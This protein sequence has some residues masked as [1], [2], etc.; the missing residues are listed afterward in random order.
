L[1]TDE[2]RINDWKANPS[3]SALSQKWGIDVRNVH[4][5][6][7]RVEGKYNIELRVKEHA[8][9][10]KIPVQKVGYRRQAEIKGGEVIVGSDI[11]EWPGERSVAFDAFIK[12]IQRRKPKMVIL[13]GDSLDGS[14]ISRH[15]PGGWADLPELADEL[16]AVQERMGE[17]E[18]V[19][20]EIPLVF[21]VGN[22]DARFSST[23]A[24]KAPDFIKINGT[25]LSDHL[26]AWNFC[27]SI[28]I[29]DDVVIKH[30]W[31]Q[32]Q[33]AKWQNVLKSGKTMVTG[34]THRLHFEAFKDYNDKTR[35]GIEC[36]T[37]MEMSTESDKLTWTEDAPLN[38]HQGFVVLTFDEDGTLLE[39]EFCR[40]IKGFAY[41]RGEKIV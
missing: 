40:V 17:V 12:L 36:G 18:S 4:A 20:G 15:P 3:P 41:F 29:N 23:L 21:P 28:W 2:Q 35:Y 38:W 9:K 1:D 5:W 25:D 37:L 16:A 24:Q 26:P 14:K 11:H 22:H 8:P 27:W 19:T 34:H 6:R 33:N 30:R 39:P 31:H 7:R 13:N 10:V 32:G